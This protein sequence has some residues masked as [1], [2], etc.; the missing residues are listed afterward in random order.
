MDKLIRT[1][2]PLGNVFAVKYDEN[3]NKIKEINPNYYNSQKDDGIGIEY[4]Y[5]TNH[6]RIS[7]IFR[8]E[9]CQER[10]MTLRAI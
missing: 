2:D 8:T 10:N 3:G 6:R 9:A 5:D 4:K 7:T 1:I